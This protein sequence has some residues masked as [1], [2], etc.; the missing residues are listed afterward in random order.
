MGGNQ[1][2][3]I[4]RSLEEIKSNFYGA[5]EGL[6]TSTEEELHTGYK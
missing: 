6:K 4:K 5:F 3:H 1:N 2:V